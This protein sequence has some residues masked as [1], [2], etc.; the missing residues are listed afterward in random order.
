MLELIS[1]KYTNRLT[2]LICDKCN[3]RLPELI[4]NKD[5]NVKSAKKYSNRKPGPIFNKYT[6]VTVGK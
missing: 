3:N 2:E 4:C 6:V 1:T 5:D